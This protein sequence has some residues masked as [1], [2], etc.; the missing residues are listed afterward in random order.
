[1]WTPGPAVDLSRPLKGAG[2]APPAPSQLTTWAQCWMGP[3]FGK[4]GGGDQDTDLMEKLS[5]RNDVL[6]NPNM[7]FY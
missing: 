7:A 6:E 1:M 3:A 5:V 2:G 4:W